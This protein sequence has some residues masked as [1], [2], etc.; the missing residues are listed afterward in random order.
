MP[1]KTMSFTA[2]EA[3]NDDIRTTKLRKIEARDAEVGEFSYN[4][5]CYAAPP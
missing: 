4:R 3:S 5:F 2:S 1:T